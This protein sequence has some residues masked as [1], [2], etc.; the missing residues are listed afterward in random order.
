MLKNVRDKWAESTLEDIFETGAPSA[1]SMPRSWLAKTL[2]ES[3]EVG[4]SY[5]ELAEMDRLVATGIGHKS[6]PDTVTESATDAL[7]EDGFESRVAGFMK[8]EHERAHAASWIALAAILTAMLLLVLGPA[9]LLPGGGPDTEYTV[10]GDGD[11]RAL[12]N[13]FCIDAGEVLI[14]PAGSSASC[15]LA[16]V[17]QPTFRDEAARG[18]Y[19]SVFAF[20]PDGATIPIL[21]NPSAPGSFQLAANGLEQ[22]VG[23]PRQLELNYGLGESHI[24]YIAA[25]KPL[26]WAIMQPVLRGLDAASSP[27][28]FTPMSVGTRVAANL[29][30]R[31]LVVTQIP[32][33]ITA[34]E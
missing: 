2:K 9:G 25:D 6:A 13:V 30:S 15:P 7:L 5:Y 12:G 23:P 16:G 31:P 8:G 21:P 4:D 11:P 33:V 29:G 18:L 27:D 10:R 19:V 24:V 32:L 1:F 14:R 34:P 20:G 3:P 26:D 17:I 28:R 22:T